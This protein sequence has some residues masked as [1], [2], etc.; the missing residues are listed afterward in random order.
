MIAT[1]AL[2]VIIL[3]ILVVFFIVY[4]TTKDDDD[5]NNGGNGSVDGVSNVDGELIIQPNSDITDGDTRLINGHVETSGLEVVVAISIQTLP[6]RSMNLRLT[7]V[8]TDLSDTD[9]TSTIMG[10]FDVRTDADGNIIHQHDGDNTRVGFESFNNQLLGFH[11]FSLSSSDGHILVNVHGTDT[12][13]IS[14]YVA[15]DI[16][17]AEV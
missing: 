2:G 11:T 12:V 8:M 10:I 9:K 17:S 1:F 7:D 3:I 16:T 6:N 15:A 5:D 4:M 13:D 14:H